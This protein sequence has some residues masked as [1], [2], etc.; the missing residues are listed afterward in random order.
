MI[1]FDTLATKVDTDKLHAIFLLKKNIWQ[2]IIKMILGYPPIAMLESLKKQ[3]IIITS[4]RQGYKS[5]EGHHDYKMST[6]VTY[7]GREQPMDIRR[8]NDN[9]KD[10]KLKCFNCNK[11]RYMAKNAEQRI[12][13]DKLGNVSS[14]IKKNTL[15]RTAKGSRQ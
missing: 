12:I 4:V 15:Q 6:G 9:F 3:K 5:T 8:F 11:Y 2:D 10:R 13:N 7:G 1:E 14:V